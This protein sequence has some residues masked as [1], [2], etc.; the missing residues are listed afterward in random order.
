MYKVR[1]VLRSTEKD[2]LE[3]MEESIEVIDYGPFN[4]DSVSNTLPV[5]LKV[6]QK[7]VLHINMRPSVQTK[8]Q[9]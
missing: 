1:A 2:M 4:A 7:K 3:N 9:T 8:Q 5:I 6:L